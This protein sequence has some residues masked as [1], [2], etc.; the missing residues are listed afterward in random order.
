MPVTWTLP[1]ESP[2]VATYMIEAGSAPGLTDVATLAVPGSQISLQVLGPPPGR[3]F[4]R[5]RGVNVTGKGGPSAEVVVAV[6]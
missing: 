5:V 3:F 4:V 6:P 2:A 1:A